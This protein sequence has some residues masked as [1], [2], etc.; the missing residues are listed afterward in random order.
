MMSPFSSA[1]NG[2]PFGVSIAGLQSSGNASGERVVELLMCRHYV[3]RKGCLATTA[4]VIDT[5]PIRDAVTAKPHT[6]L[7]L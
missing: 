4:Y 1:N 6:I 5:A 2:K 7:V 3:S